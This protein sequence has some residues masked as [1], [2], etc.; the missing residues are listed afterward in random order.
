MADFKEA[1]YVVGAISSILT[2][3]FSLFAMIRSGKLLQFIKAEDPEKW[4]MREEYSKFNHMKR[5]FWILLNK[6]YTKYRMEDETIPESIQVFLNIVKIPEELLK[7]KDLRNVEITGSTD[8]RKMDDFVRKIYPFD[9]N[10]KLS[11]KEGSILDSEDFEKFNGYRSDL[12]DF[13]DR[14]TKKR[15]IH[16]VKEE[17]YGDKDLLVALSWLDY[18]HRTF[19]NE[20]DKL[21]ENMYKLANSLFD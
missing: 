19:V 1:L 17:Y 16:K 20:S 2:A 6:A 4:N 18:A 8:Q 13:W 9:R 10:A 21:K 3:A 5:Q 11:N 12:A 15:S 7:A 14:W